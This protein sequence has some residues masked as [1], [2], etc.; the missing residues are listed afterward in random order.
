MIFYFTGTGNSLAAA[1]QLAVPGE[2][3]I[4]MAEAN[5]TGQFVYTFRKGE[6][7]GFVYPEYCSSVPLPVTDFVR[8]L[9][10]RGKGYVYAVVT[11]GGGAGK[12][13]AYL[14]LCLAAR[15]ITL[16]RAFSVRMPNNAVFYSDTPSPEAVRKTLT[17]AEEKLKQIK[18]QIS[19]KMI[20][21][22]KGKTTAPLMH[23]IYDLART[24]KPFS[25]NDHCIGCGRCEEIC[26]EN[27]IVLENGKPVWR[28]DKCAV[29]A[30]CINR[31]PVEAIQYGR[32]TAG[33]RRYVH[34]D[35]PFAKKKTEP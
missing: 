19:S 2:A 10:F 27:V 9:Q 11:S 23:S 16:H 17:Q 24:A 25:V 14:D 32:F 4:D 7:A 20:V 6:K 15:G 8:R 12:S 31:C 35:F 21:P 29:C 34:P 26:P 3:L 22:V 1:K 5:R 30:A 33:R 13:A 28:S 18:A